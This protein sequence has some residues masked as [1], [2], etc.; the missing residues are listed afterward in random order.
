MKTVL[1]AYASRMGS[2]QEIAVAIADQLV[3]RGLEVEVMA[4]VDAANAQGFDAVLLG[5]AV[6]MGQWDKHAV[7]YLRREATDLAQRPAWLFQSGPSGPLAENG[8]TGPPRAVKRL[9][10]TIGLAPPTTFGGNLDPSRATGKV[11]RWV[12]NSDLAGDSRDWDQIR[13]WADDIADQLTAIPTPTP[14]PTSI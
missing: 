3:K 6:Y 9:C 1:V 4:A 10:R 8:H 2:T 12:T 13:A 7:D 11:A 14:T 5:S